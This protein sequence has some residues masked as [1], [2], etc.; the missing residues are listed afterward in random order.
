MA[1]DIAFGLVFGVFALVAVARHYSE[2][3]T[4]IE[5]AA[6]FASMV[7]FTRLYFSDDLLDVVLLTLSSFIFCLAYISILIRYTDKLFAWT[8][9]LL[10]GGSLWA[11]LPLYLIF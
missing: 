3:G 7:F 2:H 5:G 6:V 10:T 4:A 1:Y 9:I 8:T 11:L